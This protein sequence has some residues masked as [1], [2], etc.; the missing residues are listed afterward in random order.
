MKYPVFSSIWFSPNPVKSEN[1]YRSGAISEPLDNLVPLAVELSSAEPLILRKIPGLCMLSGV[2]FRYFAWQDASKK[3]KRGVF[4]YGSARQMKHMLEKMKQQKN[5]QKI[6]RDIQ[7]S[8]ETFL[9]REPKF[10][11]RRK[12][13]HFREKIY[14]FGVVNVTPDSFYN[15]GKYTEPQQA[16]EHALQLVEEGCDV[17]DVGGESSRPGSEPISAQEE[18]KR[19][20]PVIEGIRKQSRIPISIDTTKSIVA[21]E[22]ISAGAE[23]INDISGLQMDEKMMIVAA[24]TKSPIVINHIQGTPKTMQVQPSYAH[25]LWEIFSYFY[26]RVERL[27]KV[28]VHNIILDPG[29]GFGKTPQHNAQILRNL[30]YFSS[31]GFPIMV[32]VSRKSFIGYYGGGKEPAERLE[33]SISSAATAVIFGAHILRV[34]DVL[35]TQKALSVLRPVL[36]AV[37]PTYST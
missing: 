15:G 24:E 13:W 14:L 10:S 4:L 23:I 32:G 25:L 37:H 12:R 17:V 31:L 26:E 21:R 11:L 33:G 28:G 3:E 19:V 9:Q 18:L 34:H 2:Q 30:S 7:K 27:N 8:V 1:S 16:I 6:S 35:S 5:L 36:Q 22:A 29:I 20:L